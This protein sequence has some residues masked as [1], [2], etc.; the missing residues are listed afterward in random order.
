[1]TG[2]LLIVPAAGRGSRLGSSDPKIL[3]RVSGLP[4][5]DH[6]E[7]LYRR[8][9]DMTD[10]VRARLAALGWR[11]AVVEQVEPTGMLDAILL[12]RPEVERS[13]AR[14][15]WIT[16]C[17][18]IAMRPESIA[19]LMAL[20]AESPDADVVMPS[21]RGPEPY[22][23]LER[24]ASGRIVR[25]LQR[26]E[27]DAM[28][29]TG[30]S[31]AGL[32]SLPRRAFL[33]DLPRFAAATPTGST[34]AERNFVP[35]IVGRDVVTFPVEPIEATGVNTPEELAAVHSHPGVQRGAV[36]R[37]A[38]R[39]HPC[40]RHRATRVHARDHRRRRLLDRRDGGDRRGGA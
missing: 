26:R 12:A 2:R 10:R 11:A 16:W 28:P 19:R 32:F 40:R 8:H 29:E 14:R 17:D 22:T 25:F 35:F 9:V 18:Q 34:T 36:H 1:M 33:E 21:A 39:A 15:V 37:H 5:L 7:R 23:H 3:T 20:E 38:A 31:D 4:M 30:E 13:S 27:N 24:D 6:L